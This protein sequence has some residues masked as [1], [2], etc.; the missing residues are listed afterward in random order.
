MVSFNR[1]LYLVTGELPVPSPALPRSVHAKMTELRQ[2]LI[3]CV[4]EAQAIEGQLLQLALEGSLREYGDVWASVSRESVS[5][6]VLDVL[7][8]SAINSLPIPV[9][10][11]E[12]WDELMR[13]HTT[14]NLD[15]IPAMRESFERVTAPR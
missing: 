13:R 6:A 15:T 9:T 10:T 12:E 4:Q 1:P 3:A 11:P 7:T 8:R 2:A 5:E 14:I